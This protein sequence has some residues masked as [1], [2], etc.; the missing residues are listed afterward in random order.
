MRLALGA[1]APAC[2]APARARR[3]ELRLGRMPPRLAPLQHRP[4]R[5][6]AGTGAKTPVAPSIQGAGGD[7]RQRSAQSA[8]STCD[9]GRSTHPRRRALERGGNAVDAAVAVGYALAVTH[10]SAGN[11]GGGGFMLVRMKG[12]PTV[13]ID[14][15]E[16]A[17]SGLTREAFDRMIAGGA[18]GPAAVGVPGTPAGLNLAHSRFGKLPLRELIE[19]AIEL[20]RRATGSVR[21]KVRPLPVL[22][23]AAQGS[24]ARHLAMAIVQA[25]R[26]AAP[27]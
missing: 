16:T 8:A 7:S 1:F 3:A 5:I 15:R 24:A 25:Q 22:A 12:G 6:A 20:A 10:P 4:R 2:F 21:A 13:A 19:P 17:P 26:L 27:A 11:I 18:I 9:F 14:F 23:G